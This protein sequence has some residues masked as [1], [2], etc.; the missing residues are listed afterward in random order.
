MNDW[1]RPFGP[2]N[3]RPSLVEWLWVYVAVAVFVFL[4]ALI[5]LHA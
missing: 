5:G 4:I 3:P 1:Y 2:D